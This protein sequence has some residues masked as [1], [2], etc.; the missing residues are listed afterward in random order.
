MNALRR[1][2]L[3][4]RDEVPEDLR[5]SWSRAICSQL[6]GLLAEKALHFPMFYVSFRSEV[7]THDLI[8][9]RLEQGL[10]V[11]V[12]ITHLATHTLEPRR[13]THWGQLV[14]GAYGILEPDAQITGPAP[15]QELS[16]VIVPGSVFDL[17]GGRYGYGGGYYDRFLM[18]AAPQAVRI[19]LAFELQVLES[20]PLARHDQRMHWII[21]ENRTI[22]PF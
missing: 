7:A 11:A 17:S 9:S 21:T 13:I 4:R 1:S 20:I 6:Q 5:M 10:F 14:P 8:R 18:N 19:G 16:A 12:P 15:P 2:I 3:M 22:G